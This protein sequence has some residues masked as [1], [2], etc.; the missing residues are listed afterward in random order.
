MLAA[1]P[2]KDEATILKHRH[3]LTLD[4]LLINECKDLPQEVYEYPPN[5]RQTF[6]KTHLIPLKT[7]TLFDKRPSGDCQRGSCAKCS[8]N[9]CECTT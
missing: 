6:L 9:V 5:L 1:I 8:I 3:I 2:G 7:N 4:P